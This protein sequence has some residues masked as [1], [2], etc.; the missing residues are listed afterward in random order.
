MRAG[1]HPVSYQNRYR[2]ELGLT[3]S[4]ISF[5][6]EEESKIVAVRKNVPSALA[7]T[8][9]GTARTPSAAGRRT[10]SAGRRT[11]SAAGRTPSRA[12]AHAYGTAKTTVALTGDAAA[13]AG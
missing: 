5:E 13:T 11:P 4:I 2:R 7:R 3:T 1:L 9:S 10:P 8:P 6:V 12:H